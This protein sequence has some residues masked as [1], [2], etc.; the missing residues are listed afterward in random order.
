MLND[1]NGLFE[2]EH[3]LKNL[4]EFYQMQTLDIKNVYNRCIIYVCLEYHKESAFFGTKK[5]NA[6]LTM[7]FFMTIVPIGKS[8]FPGYRMKASTIKVGNTQ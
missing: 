1:T 8:N 5:E 6:R 3:L 7:V 2:F 4:I